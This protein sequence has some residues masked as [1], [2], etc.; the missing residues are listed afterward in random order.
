MI[1]VIIMVGS[2]PGKEYRTFIPKFESKLIQMHQN[3]KRK[4]D[5][6]K[7]YDFGTHLL[8]K[9]IMQAEQQAQQGLQQEGR[10]KYDKSDSV[11]TEW[12]KD[13]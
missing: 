3:G 1:E 6:L 4:C 5:N 10:C 7:E 12:R 9:W 11:Q 8:D 13:C 2:I